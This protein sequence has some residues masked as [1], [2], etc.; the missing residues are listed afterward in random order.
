MLLKLERMVARLGKIW[1]TVFRRSDQTYIEARVGEYHRFWHAAADEIGATFTKIS[2]Y[3]WDV[4]KDG[5][6]TR[7]F[8][9]IVE[10]DNAVTMNLVGSK[11]VVAK[12]LADHGIPVPPGEEFTLAEL[13]KAYRF[14]EEHPG[15]CVVKPAYFTSAGRGVTTHIKTRKQL[16]RAAIL[17]SLHERY[18]MIESQMA[19]ESCR[20]L[21][22]Q[23]RMIHAVRRRGPRLFG[24]G[25]SPIRDL[26]AKHNTSHASDPAHAIDMD[27]DCLFTLQYQGLTPDSVPEDGAEFVVR[28]VG[29]SH[30]RGVEVRTVYNEDITDQVGPGF[31]RVVEDAAKLIGAEFVGVDLITRDITA[32]LEDCGG[33]ILEINTTPGLHHHYDSKTELYPA[34]AVEVLTALLEK[35]RRQVGQAIE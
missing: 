30:R 6:S 31:R 15:D 26:I 18:M 32:D 2:D 5:Y 4:S 9:Y 28:S 17:A 13:N 24:D 20:G 21:V 35:S 16:R 7:I 34:V 23:G 1:S 33:A 19:G 8:N 25:I 3:I 12:M 27:A 22:L 10:F 11:P 29:E 14:L